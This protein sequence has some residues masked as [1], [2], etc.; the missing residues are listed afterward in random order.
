MF[1]GQGYS[2]SVYDYIPKD[3]YHMTYAWSEFWIF[4]EHA[5]NQTPAEESNCIN[6]YTLIY[7]IS[8]QRRTY[9]LTRQQNIAPEVEEQLIC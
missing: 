8:R 4:P 6:Q 5:L 7:L 1:T 3:R 9:K 2:V